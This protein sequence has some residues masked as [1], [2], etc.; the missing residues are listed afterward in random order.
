MAEPKKSYSELEHSH[1]PLQK[2]GSHPILTGPQGRVH[3]R[4]QSP[5]ESLGRARTALP[6]TIPVTAPQVPSVSSGNCTPTDH[7]VTEARS[8]N[9]TIRWRQEPRGARRHGT[10]AGESG[11]V[12]VCGEVVRAASVHDT[13]CTDPRSKHT[14]SD[15]DVDVDVDPPAAPCSS[16]THRPSSSDIPI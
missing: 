10:G 4:T 5:A 7:E 3:R 2:D 16:C 1:Q 12:K 15:E 8:A 6:T 11:L 14:T 9:H 13:T